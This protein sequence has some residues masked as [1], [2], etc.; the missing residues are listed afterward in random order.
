MSSQHGQVVALAA[1]IADAAKIV[2]A[3][4]AKSSKP[5]VP[6]LDDT[7]PHLYD[8]MLNAELRTA[9]QTIEGACAQLS[10]TVARPNHTIVN[11]LMNFYEPVC[12][13]V[14][15]TFKIPDILQEKPSGMHISEIGKRTGIEERK[16][17]RILRL[18]AT[19]HVFREV[20][21]NVFANNRLSIQLLSSNPLSSL[22]LHF[23]DECMKSNVLLS[24]VLAD[25]EWGHSYATNQTAFNKYANY[26]DPV[27][28]YFEKDQECGAALGERFGLGM[29]GWGAACE[30]QAV[31]HEFPWNE[32][33]EGAS[34]CDVGGGVGNITL[35]LAKAY[36]KLQL[37]LQ[38]LPATI[39]QARNEVWP[40][41]CPEA[42]AEN[43]IT[44]EPIDFFAGSPVSGCDVYYMKNIIHD[45][46]DADCIKILSNIRDAMG[47]NSRILVQEYILQHAN[48]VPDS[49]SAFVQAP[50]PM[51]PNYGAGR[52][53]QY[54]LDLDMMTMLNSEE[55][56]LPE[57]VKLGEAAGLKFEK[58]WDFGETGLV[59]YRLP[60]SA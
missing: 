3:H 6:S 22:G 36:P 26:P 33:G 53:R 52:I 18:L 51:L 60:S 47:P 14:A 24:D 49:E 35:Q 12:L 39:T 30:A 23:T 57:F 15:I 10:A 48:R 58:L 55:R 20:S 44:F 2:E 40:A 31:I 1:I 9:I 21:E 59:E 28:V 7:E 17:G 54:N 37:V 34:V 56:R 41:Q 5:Y 32:L 16:V 25:K 19:K 42:I 27:F 13:N 4:Y 45:W 46:P 38:D 11:K 43:R 29:I 8:E 50:A